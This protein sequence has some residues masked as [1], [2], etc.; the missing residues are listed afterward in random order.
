[1]ARTRIHTGRR[2]VSAAGL[3]RRDKAGIVTRTGHQRL[4]AHLVRSA[5]FVATLSFAKPDDRLYCEM[6]PTERAGSVAVRSTNPRRHDH[7]NRNVKSVG[8]R[9]FR[10]WRGRRGRLGGRFACGEMRRGVFRSGA[11]RR[12]TK[13]RAP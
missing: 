11:A 10:Y 6:Y 4:A 2:G 8:R 7:R 13:R 12:E 9:P 5:G 3:F 1:M